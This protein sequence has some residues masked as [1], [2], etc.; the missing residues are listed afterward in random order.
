VN[1]D[2]HTTVIGSFSLPTVLERLGA[3]GEGWVKDKKERG[4]VGR[5]KGIGSLDV[6]RGVEKREGRCVVIE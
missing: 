3:I 4:T 6:G 5:G 2:R 1:V